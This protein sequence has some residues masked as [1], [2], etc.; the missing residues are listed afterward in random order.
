MLVR[1]NRREDEREEDDMLVLKIE[2]VV[3]N[4][5]FV[6]EDSIFTK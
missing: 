4:A 3:V 1:K 6:V 2:V 5:I